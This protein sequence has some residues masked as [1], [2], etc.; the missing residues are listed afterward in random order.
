MQQQDI[1]QL[2]AKGITEAQIEKQIQQFQTGFPFLKIEAPASI[3]RGIMA[4]TEG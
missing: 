1:Q 4:P 3:G 2:Q